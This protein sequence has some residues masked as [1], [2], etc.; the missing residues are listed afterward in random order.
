MRISVTVS[1]DE[2]YASLDEVFDKTNNL[3]IVIETIEDRL[4][5]QEHYYLVLSQHLLREVICF[6]R[7]LT[8]VKDK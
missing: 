5:F 6:E 1:K 7:D 3:G 2:L 4:K 8:L